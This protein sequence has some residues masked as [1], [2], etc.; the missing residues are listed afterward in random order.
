MHPRSLHQNSYD[1][2]KLISALPALTPFVILNQFGNRSIDFGNPGAVLQLNKALLKFHYK[3]E[4]WDIPEGYL[5]PPIPGRAEYLHHIA[6][7]LKETGKNSSIRGLDI[8]VGANAIYCILANRIY[9]WKMRGTDVEE[10]SVKAAGSNI[11]NNPGTL[12]DIEVKLQP[13]R[14]SIFK[15]MIGDQDHFHFTMCNPPFYN[16]ENDAQKANFQKSRNLGQETESAR[17]FGGQ[18]TELWCNGGEALFLKR[19]IKESKLFKNQVDWFTCL[20]SKK[21]NLAKLYKQLDKVK[22]SFT[23]IEMEVG[24]KK[25][26]IIAWQ[27]NT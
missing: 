2:R 25:S 5:C 6:D 17:N 14:G 23:S 10:Q 9:D 18:A 15:G 24:N 26:R 20:V 11:L 7:L 12:K 8:G 13:D 4:N 1:F 21:E 16:S 3:I 19:M 27:F 22:A